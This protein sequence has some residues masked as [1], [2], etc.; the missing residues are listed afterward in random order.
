MGL[1]EGHDVS[2]PYTRRSQ[3]AHQKRS[4]MPADSRGWPAALEMTVWVISSEG[5]GRLGRRGPRWGYRKGTMYRAP[6]H[7]GAKLHIRSGR[8][9][10]RILAGGE[11]IRRVFRRRGGGWGRL[12]WDWRVGGDRRRS[13]RVHGGEVGF[14]EHF[15][16]HFLFVFAD[17]VLAGDGAAG[18]DA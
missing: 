17:A 7:A 8:R 6:T 16:H 4:A 5:V 10:R 2:C 11:C 12:W 9:C 1:Q 15:G 14:G 13:G 3:V 18:G